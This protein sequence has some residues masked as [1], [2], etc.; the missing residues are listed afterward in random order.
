MNMTMKWLLKREIWEH[1]GGFVWT[2][3]IVGA[4][5]ALGTLVSAIVLT[6]LKSQH[7]INI[8]GEQVTNLGNAISPEHKARVIEFASQGY[9]M[10]AG[11]LFM[12]MTVVIFFFCLGSLF[13][14]R[15]DRSVLFWKSLPVSDGETVLSKAAM[16][17]V[18]APLITTA[19][20]VITGIA[21]LVIAVATSAAT[22][23]NMASVFLAPATYL[24]PFKLLAVLPV[25]LVWALPT[26]GWLMMVSAWARTKVFLWAVG[27]PVLSVILLAWFNAIFNFGLDMKWFWGNIVG[28]GLGSVLPGIW[29]AFVD[30]PGGMHIGH[31]EPIEFGI[32]TIQ[33]W[34]T[35]GYANPWIGAALG[36]GM[37]YAATRIRRWKDEG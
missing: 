35:L 19:F 16:A 24:A 28:R 34:K 3:A 11:P 9:L 20:A 17:L 18:A 6:V 12:A 37:L 26:V 7:G 8:N 32:L 29:F 21:F 10:I 1:K 30:P 2:P 23:L 14:E 33:S 15:K 13:D 36:G 25:Y 4:I 27:V 31:R 22:G 5:I